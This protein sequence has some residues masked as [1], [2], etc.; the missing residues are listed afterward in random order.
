MNVS[1]TNAIPGRST[2]MAT[3]LDSEAGL[4]PGGNEAVRMV[5]PSAAGENA[6]FANTSPALI[7]TSDG[8][9]E[10][11]AGSEFRSL[12]PIAAPPPTGCW[13]IAFPDESRTAVET[14]ILAGNPTT[15]LSEAALEGPVMRIADRAITTVP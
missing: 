12:N 13:E 6:T 14:M 3:A 9:R 4:K 2:L 11:T 5:L 8:A 15:V 1:P 10:P 7:F